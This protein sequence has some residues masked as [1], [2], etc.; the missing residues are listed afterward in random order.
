MSREAVFAG[1]YGTECAVHCTC[2]A[3]AVAVAVAVAGAEAVAA[4]AEW[5]CVSE[6]TPL[7]LRVATAGAASPSS[8]WWC[9]GGGRE[10]GGETAMHER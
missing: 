4:E 6:V 5:S 10:T 7:S 1:M 3:L 9:H 2:E 8:W